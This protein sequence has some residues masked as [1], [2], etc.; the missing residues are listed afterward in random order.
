MVSG[1]GLRTVVDS[2]NR[3]LINLVNGFTSD[4][5]MNNPNYSSNSPVGQLFGFD[6]VIDNNIG[7]LAASTTAGPIFGNMG[8]AM[9]QRVVTPG[10]RILRLVERYAEMLAVGYY[11]F[12]RTDIRSN[13]LRAAVT[14]T[15]STS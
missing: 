5:Q 12:Y 7:N 9:V 6:V 1:L 8:H 11:G 4:H 3:P 13:D 10:I 15:A 14:V 2:N